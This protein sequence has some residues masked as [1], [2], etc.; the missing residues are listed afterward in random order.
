MGKGSALITGASSGIGEA[1]AK[2]FAAQGFDLVITARRTAR[3]ELL[4]ESLRNQV[5]VEVI[6]SDLSSKAGVE[7]LIG[8]LKQ[9]PIDILVNNAGI[10]LQGAFQADDL[11]AVEQLLG[12]NIHALTQLTHHF[13]PLM[14][15]CGRGRILNV[16]SVAAF[17]PLASMAVYAASKAYVLS[18]TESLAE[19]VRGTGVCLTAL[20]PGWTETSMA[21]GLQGKDI[22]PFL[23][24]RAEDVA[25]EGYEALMGQEVIRIP[26]VANQVAL[27]WAKHQPRWLVR[28]IGGW[29]A[30]LNVSGG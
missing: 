8:D 11:A 22:P 20:C 10:S 25:R 1:L 15:Q 21:A 18:F 26:G 24:S 30:K 19:E 12:L 17:Q 23:L 5:G 27:A 13:L 14:I 6:T 16:A 9:Q 3:L 29:F 2:Q 28:G 7:Q 4:A